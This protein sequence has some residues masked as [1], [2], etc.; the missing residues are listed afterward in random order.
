MDQ[1]ISSIYDPE[2]LPQNYIY[3]IP[4]P[5]FSD[6]KNH[7][8]PRHALID[9]IGNQKNEFPTIY[10]IFTHDVHHRQSSL[11][12]GW[13]LGKFQR[14]T[15][16]QIYGRMENSSII[17]NSRNNIISMYKEMI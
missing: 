5:L 8:I 9:F 7:T 1:K 11:S 15:S 3:Q 4:I 17:R 10:E 6:C 13:I 16:E 14:S 2:K 12:N